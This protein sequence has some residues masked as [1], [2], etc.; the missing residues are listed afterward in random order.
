MGELPSIRP[1]RD[2]TTFLHFE[3]GGL[4]RRCAEPHA[5]NEEQTG[6]HNSERATPI[7]GLCQGVFKEQFILRHISVFPTKVSTK[8]LS[9]FEV[10]DI[11]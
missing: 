2:L 1:L 5:N 7:L 6:A 8:S 10:Q 4:E 9:A 11:K 3:S